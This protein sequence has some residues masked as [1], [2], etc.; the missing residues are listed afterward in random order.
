M[1]EKEPPA[2]PVGMDE[3]TGE[4]TIYDRPLSELAGGPY[5]H[6]MGR[7]LAA[8][9][10]RAQ[11][12]VGKLEKSK[13][14][15][16]TM[17][18]KSYSYDYAPLPELLKAIRPAFAEEGLLLMWGARQGDM[19]TL[20]SCSVV[21]VETGQTYTAELPISLP[22]DPKKA[23]SKLTYYERYMTGLVSGTVAEEDDDATMASEGDGRGEAAPRQRGDDRK[24][25]AIEYVE[26]ALREA[27]GGEKPW[28]PR[29]KMSVLKDV[30]G[31]GKWSDFLR[32]PVEAMA[33]SCDPKLYP[34]LHGMSRLVRTIRLVQAETRRPDDVDHSEWP[35]YHDRQIDAAMDR[36]GEQGAG[37]EYDYPEAR[38]SG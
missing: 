8:A 11:L 24:S 5:R 10:L 27:F 25:K 38:F 22:D 26:N 34:E 30:Y 35:M 14:V 4:V 1:A 18:G 19:C 2:T 15:T 17:E 32:L 3:K 20:L 16:I 31:S 29:E 37:A 21:H 33:E 23:G 28:D 7:E 36:A 12:R 6:I 9:I 13:T